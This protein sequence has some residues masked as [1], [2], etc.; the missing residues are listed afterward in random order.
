MVTRQTI[1]AA[2]VIPARYGSKGVPNKNI[3]NLG[4]IPLLAHTIRLA[5]DTPCIDRVLV[6]TEHD[7]IAGIARNYG[8]EIIHRPLELATATALTDPVILHAVEVGQISEEIILTLEPTS[9][10]RTK[11]TIE[12]CVSIFEETE[13]DSV[14]GVVE[15]NKKSGQIV[16]GVFVYDNS[17]N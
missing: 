16:D 14:I 9:P 6:S 4:G 15:N 10:F 17:S 1:S 13:A 8:A 5:I 3:R 7:D 2:A 11:E 12:R